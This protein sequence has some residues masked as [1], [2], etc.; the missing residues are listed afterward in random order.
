[1]Q[2]TSLQT[3]LWPAILLT[4]YFL[5]GL[6]LYALRTARQGQ[7]R[8]SNLEGRESTAIL[9][10]WVR[11]YFAWVMRPVF[12]GLRALGIPADAITT[13]STLLATASAVALAAGH[14]TLGGW[15][16]LGGGICDF[17]DGK[18]ARARQQTSQ[19]GAALDSILDR[20]SDGVVLAGLA[21]Y[22]RQSWVMLLTLALLIASLLVSYA[23][24]KG[25]GFGVDI[26]GGLAQRAERVVVLGIALVFSHPLHQAWSAPG[27][28]QPMYWLTVGAL[29]LLTPLAVGTALLRLA[30]LHNALG[31]QLF[32]QWG[33]A[34]QGSLLRHVTSALVATALDFGAVWLLVSTLALPAWLA[35]ALGCAVGAL[36]NFSINRAW[37]FGSQ[38]RLD[39]QSGRYLLV[40]SSSAL[41]NA[42]G[43]AVLLLLPGLDYR[44]AWLIARVLIFLAWNYPLQK[45]WV[46]EGAQATPQPPQREPLASKASSLLAL[47]LAV[48]LLAAPSASQAQTFSPQV[49][50]HDKY[51]ESWT[52][53]T[54]LEDGTYLQGQ[55]AL[56]NIGPGDRNGGC[57]L[58]ISAPGAPTWTASASVEDGQWSHREGTLAV[59][60][61]SASAQGQELV[62]RFQLKGAQVSIA[63]RADAKPTQPPQGQLKGSDGSYQTW[64]LAPWSQARVTLQ[65]PGAAP[66]TT[67]ALA[68]ADH[69][70]GTT[71][72]AEI[73]RQWVR[74]R[75]LSGPSP[76]LMLARYPPGAAA[77]QG[78]LWRQ[79]QA[80]LPLRSFSL[81]GSA[82]AGWTLRAQ[83]GAEEIALQVQA[84]L[85]RHAPVE[86]HGV[87]GSLASALVGNPVTYTY[88][89]EGAPWVI[90]EV[91][92]ADE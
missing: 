18:L 41:L 68:Y 84:P 42:G 14:F 50:D 1:M 44:L 87:L 35:T 4:T 75:A 80:P 67:Q 73:A 27:D 65:A 83:A 45:T 21:W 57:R 8:D 34:G 26:K 15:L 64:V 76:W 13:L 78:W 71:L 9:G 32:Q 28:P 46:F 51:G 74:A 10:L 33:G 72:P 30:R 20:Y 66:R 89:T 52:V 70:R 16:M 88:R 31:G 82:K 6:A 54:V 29:L 49:P 92:F 79:G 12:A 61:C 17:L 47:P 36:A 19:A 5:G 37:T 48:G 69:T 38:G 24:A 81:R 43:V 90:M 40:S 2:W 59:G 25:E 86:E 63:L 91:S 85:Y 58:L 53:L 60:G 62:Y 3:T 23:R 56:S 55:L 7:W 22:Y 39:L 77:P 11:L